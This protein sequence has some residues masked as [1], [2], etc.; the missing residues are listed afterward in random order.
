M[1]SRL[2]V[3]LAAVLVAFGSSCGDGDASGGQEVPISAPNSGAVSAVAV[4]TASTSP[5]ETDKASPASSPSSW[6]S[7]PPSPVAE[8]S[9]GVPE[10]PPDLVVTNGSTTLELR[11]WTY[12]FANG[13]ADG[14]PPDPLPSIGIGERL[15]VTFPLADWSFSAAFQR[16][17]DPCARTQTVDLEQGG[18]TTFTLGPAGPPGTYQVELFGRGNGDL[19][20]S[21]E[22]TTT[23]AGP[24]PQ[25]SSLLAVLA[26]HDGRVDSYG[27]EFSVVNL[28]GS[29]A[30]ATALITVTAANGKSLTFELDPA[31]QWQPE[32]DAIEG[33][34]VWNGPADQGLAAAQLGPAPFTYDVV[35]TLDGVEHRAHAVWPDDQ[36]PG[37]EP[38]VA[39][40]F[41][42]PLPAWTG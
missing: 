16:A 3:G 27:V 10:A 21:F 22:W 8:P 17:G 9:G 39:L 1:G 2:C 13:C 34:V 6:V 30:T 36:I 12:C 32:C 38:S 31:P 35:V 18:P 7:S 33:L 29:P 28:A 20:V 42:P 41:V 19:F 23:A 37:N 26:D 40:T 25:P 15:D 4:D 24:M 11:P 5:D 14:F